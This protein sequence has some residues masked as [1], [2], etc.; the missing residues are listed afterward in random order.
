MS[1]TDP[2]LMKKGLRQQR[3]QIIDRVAQNGPRPYEEGIKTIHSR[4]TYEHFVNGPRPYE[5]GIKTCLV[6][7]IGGQLRT[8]PDLMKKGLR[9]E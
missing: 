3:P 1:G 6:P 9:R 2:D 5:E 7:E 4:T 8:D